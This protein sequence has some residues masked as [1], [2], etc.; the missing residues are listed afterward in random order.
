MSKVTFQF[1]FDTESG[2]FSVINVET[3]EVK[4]AKTTKAK[5]TKTKTSKEETDIPTLTLEDTKCCLNQAAIDLMGIEP[6]D[7]I[8]IK[9]S[10]DSGKL[11]P[12]IGTDEAFGTQSGNKFCKNKSFAY[13][14]AKNEELMKYGK[15]FT[16]IPDN[17]TQGI[18]ILKNPNAVEE[19]VEED[20]PDDL[21]NP[22]ID[23]ELQDLMN[24][25]DAE[26]VS[27]FQFTL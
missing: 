9:Y 7:K 14:G 16:L 8:D 11:V 15:E 2:E 22:E 3:G 20:I 23:D 24:D 26:E 21:L 5:T 13:R 10:K 25:A 1:T 12:I 17:T 18:F 4:V 19:T 6:G 27:G